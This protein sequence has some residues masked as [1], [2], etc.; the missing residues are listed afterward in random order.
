MFLLHFLVALAQ[1]QLASQLPQPWPPLVEMAPQHPTWGLVLHANVS[2]GWATTS[3]TS[4]CHFGGFW[5]FVW[6]SNTLMLWQW[7][8]TTTLE[9]FEGRTHPRHPQ[10]YTHLF[11]RL[12]SIHL[13][14]QH[15]AQGLMWDVR[16]QFLPAAAVVGYGCV[17]HCWPLE[18]NI[19]STYCRKWKKC[20]RKYF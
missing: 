16:G 13:T 1:T 10:N 14:H 19:R 9:C 15:G 12:L 4:G 8:I 18:A 11:G 3:Q 7:C 20:P 5:G 2:N 17:G 6:P